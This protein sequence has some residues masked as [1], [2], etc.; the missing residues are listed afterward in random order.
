MNKLI[1]L[2]VAIIGIIVIGVV[3]VY[4][5]Q[6]KVGFPGTSINANSDYE[7]LTEAAMSGKP[8]VIYFSTDNCPTC[9]LQDNVFDEIIPIY[10]ATY[11]FIF[12]KLSI[13][14]ANIF[15][16]WSILEVPT[17]VFADRSG[18]I[19]E[20]FDGQFLSSSSLMNEL[21]RMG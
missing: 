10:N 17:L 19:V 16:E 6:P 3:V 7:P 12:L 5:G 15:K 1:L 4:L 18:K 8:T 2:P 13:D 9:S 14:D 21:E 20:R 11:N